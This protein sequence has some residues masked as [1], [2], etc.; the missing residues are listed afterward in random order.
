MSGLAGAALEERLIDFAVRVV[1]VVESL[2][3]SMAGRHV[4]KQLL[5]SGTAPAPNYAEAR[6]AESR[7]DFAHKLKIALK[8]LRETHVWLRIVAKRSLGEAGEVEKLLRECD[9]LIAIFVASTKTLS[10]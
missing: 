1:S 3:A 5:R 9:E 6:S 2:P 7:Q 10:D 8:E 4:G